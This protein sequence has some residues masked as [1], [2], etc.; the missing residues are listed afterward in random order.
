MKNHRARIIKLELIDRI[1]D[2]LALELR[3]LRNQP[4][5]REELIG[6]ISDLSRLYR[7]LKT[8]EDSS[9]EDR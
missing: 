6:Q 4:E 1:I 7:E 8:G 5:R 9:L 2:S 3:E